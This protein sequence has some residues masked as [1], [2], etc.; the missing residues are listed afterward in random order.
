MNTKNPTYALSSCVFDKG[1]VSLCQDANVQI[2]IP[3]WEKAIFPS[4]NIRKAFSQDGLAVVNSCAACP[5]GDDAGPSMNWVRRFFN[6]G[7]GG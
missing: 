2:D 3:C 1:I 4:R 5:F 6:N 7:S